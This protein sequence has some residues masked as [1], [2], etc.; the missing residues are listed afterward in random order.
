MKL[1]IASDNQAKVTVRRAGHPGPGPRWSGR[2]SESPRLFSM[3]AAPCFGESPPCEFIYI[4]LNSKLKKSSINAK[5]FI[6]LPF[7]E[8]SAGIERISNMRNFTSFHSAKCIFS[9]VD[10]C[11]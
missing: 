11:S 7:N 6:L 4:L 1:E 3:A 5:V 10:H 9:P 2:F 8:M